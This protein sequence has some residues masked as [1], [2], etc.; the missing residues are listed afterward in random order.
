M[1]FL[2]YRS[3]DSSI[4]VVEVI[5]LGTQSLKKKKNWDKNRK[6]NLSV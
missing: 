1:Y 4:P 3:L 2:M 5:V 6:K